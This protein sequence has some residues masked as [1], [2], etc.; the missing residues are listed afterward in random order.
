VLLLVVGTINKYSPPADGWQVVHVDKSDRGIWDPAQG[1]NVPIDV[2]ADMRQMPFAD[3]SV[4]RIQCWH[5]LE[6]VNQLGGEMT[7]AEFSRILAADGV[8]DL[9]V[10]DLNYAHQ[11]QDVAE[12][13]NLIY[14]DQ[15]VMPDADLNLHRWGYT[16]TSLRA[17]L[18]D[19]GFAAERV[20]AEHPDEIR[21]I[22]RRA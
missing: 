7:I 12:I 16:E 6:H 3:H 2:Q 13:A 11:V 19:Q 1:K 8:L 20:P 14:G 9:R 15:T 4:D 22:A 10:P 18:Q 17:L 21:I 5:A